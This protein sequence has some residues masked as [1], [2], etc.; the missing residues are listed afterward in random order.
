MGDPSGIGPEIVL[1][2]LAHASVFSTCRPLVAGDGRILDRASRWLAACRLAAEA[3]WGFG[4][5]PSVLGTLEILDLQIAPPL[6][7]P[8]GTVSAASGRA[9]VGYVV[10]VCDLALAAEVDAIVTAPLNKEAMRL[11][12]CPWTGHT[13]LLA[14]RTG[15][16]N[17]AMLLAS[18]R[19]RV[20]HVSTHV[21]LEEALRRVTCKRVLATTVSAH[22]SP[23]AALRGPHGPG[24]ILADAD[25]EPWRA[26]TDRGPDSSRNTASPWQLSSMAAW[27]G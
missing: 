16:D 12:G 8:P 9:A 19:L 22:Q 15:V 2:A 23:P 17:V 26:G 18:S 3:P 14:H 25:H 20:I 7:C 11:A 27:G 5:A 13:E 6:E 21:S 24:R 1:N 10:R 4:D